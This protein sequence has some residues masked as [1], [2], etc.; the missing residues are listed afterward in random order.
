MNE[1]HEWLK[2][3]SGLW[4]CMLCQRSI[5]QNEK[6]PDDVKFKVYDYK[7]NESSLM[8]CGDSITMEKYNKKLEIINLIKKYD[9]TKEEFNEAWDEIGMDRVL[10]S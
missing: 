4:V 7:K 10:R 1:Q 3:P 2:K 8:S 9:L 5:G 6:P